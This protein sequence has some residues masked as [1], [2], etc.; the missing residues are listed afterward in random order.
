VSLDTGSAPASTEEA[1]R[2]HSILSAVREAILVW[3]AVL[4]GIGAWTIHLVFFA[5]YVRY[6]CNRSGSLWLM[7]VVTAITL[8]MTAAALVL[9]RRMLL[10]SEG[11]ESA[12]DEGGR[13]QFLARLGLLIGVVNFALI[14]LEEVY[15]VVLASRRCG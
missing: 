11:D 12:D 13:A 6:T 7:H 14:A 10:S 1:R 2:A 15:L 9:C 5:A 3:Y 4:G 8:A